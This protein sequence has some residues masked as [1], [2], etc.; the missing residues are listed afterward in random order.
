MD[1]DGNVYVI[2]AAFGNFQIFNPKGELLLAVGGRSNLDGPAKFAL[3]SSI[4]VDDDGRVYVVDQ[5]FRKVDVF[6][7]AALAEEDGYIG[8]NAIDKN[9]NA[10][11]DQVPASGGQPTEPGKDQAPTGP[12]KDE[13]IDPSK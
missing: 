8:K 12:G 6:R 1:K 5:Y 2:D 7:P 4:A 10:A 13:E 9:Q 3:P 11:G